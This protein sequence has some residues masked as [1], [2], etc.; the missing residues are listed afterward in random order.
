[1]NKIPCTMNTP[2]G[3]CLKNGYQKDF[4]SEDFASDE[5]ARQAFE[6]KK[7]NK[8]KT[9]REKSMKESLSKGFLCHLGHAELYNLYYF[10]YDDL[11]NY[12]NL[13]KEYV[14]AHHLRH[15]ECCS[16]I[17]CCDDCGITCE[18]GCNCG[19]EASNIGGRARWLWFNKEYID[20]PKDVELQKI[21]S[22]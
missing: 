18:N 2:C 7:A 13:P 20:Q 3:L 1:M 9:I 14:D 4:K 5:E 22:G 15:M 10:S 6:E 16:P 17:S 21:F 8:V 19:N 11:D 12:N